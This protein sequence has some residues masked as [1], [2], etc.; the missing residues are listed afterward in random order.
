[1]S[2]VTKPMMLDETGKRIANALELSNVYLSALAKEDVD[3]NINDLKY[4]GE[5]VRK[6]LAPKLFN[7]GDQIVVPWTDITIN[8]TYNM[9]FNIVDFRTVTLKGGIEV[10]GMVLQSHYAFPFNATFD[11]AEKEVASETAFLSS[12]NYYKQYVDNS[13]K[14][15][16]KLLTPGTDYVNGDNIPTNDTYYHNEI[17]DSSG[18]IIGGGYARWG[19]SAIRQYLNSS[20][21]K[22]EWW[23][24]QHIGDVKPGY[25]IDKAGF[26]TGFS[27]DFLSIL[28]PVEVK[29]R[30]ST[31]IPS[32]SEYEYTYD[33][34]FLCS[35]KEMYVKTT[36]SDEPYFP[37]WK[38]ALGATE[39]L[40]TTTKIPEFIHYV[41]DTKDATTVATRA[42]TSLGST[43]QAS[44][45]NQAGTVYG[46]D[47]S[48][49]FKFAPC[50]VIC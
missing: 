44:V 50:C 43:H 11:A 8:K 4:I 7:I 45:I 22:N 39:P 3:T 37:Y 12:L 13:G 17:K 18:K 30:L 42:V 46:S 20:A 27:D 23:T 32:D 28:R 35:T 16:Y 36:A 38:M 21:A 5:I 29:T 10:P 19:H 33:I 9:P 1:M 40:A 41:V 47:S 15:A 34:F 49:N 6:G 14:T 2:S 26:L 48:G 24:A 31:A 25:P